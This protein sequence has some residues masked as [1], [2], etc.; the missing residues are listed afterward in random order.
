MVLIFADRM[1]P[2]WAFFE[3]TNRNRRNVEIYLRKVQ[4]ISFLLRTT[5]IYERYEDLSLKIYRFLIFTCLVLGYNLHV[6]SCSAAAAV[7]I[8]VPSSCMHDDEDDPTPSVY[9]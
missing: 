1:V 9:E 2:P 5:T 6:L 4:R 7:I 3:K 8:Y